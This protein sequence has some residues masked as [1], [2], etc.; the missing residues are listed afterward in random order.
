[1]YKSV[2][3]IFQYFATRLTGLRNI[4]SRFQAFTSRSYP[5]QLTRSEQFWV[6]VWDNPNSL[7][8]L[9]G[10]VHQNN[11]KAPLISC[12]QSSTFWLSACKSWAKAQSPVPSLWLISVT[13][14]AGPSCWCSPGCVP[15]SWWRVGG[16]YHN[17]CVS[18]SAVPLLE[19][20]AKK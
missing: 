11:L 16:I 5:E 8:E 2:V 17:K 14:H 19:D 3:N 20:P 15:A 6:S 10:A 7:N 4:Y 1:M 13:V 9:S 18:S 12:P